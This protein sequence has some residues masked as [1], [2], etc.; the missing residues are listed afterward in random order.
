M[1]E[2]VLQNGTFPV[3]MSLLETGMASHA[4]GWFLLVTI[5]VTGSGESG[6]GSGVILDQ[7]GHILTNT[8]VVTLDGATANATAEVQLSADAAST[9]R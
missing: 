2:S 9:V 4:P 5:A 8:H 6:T 1:R 3:Q 7:Q